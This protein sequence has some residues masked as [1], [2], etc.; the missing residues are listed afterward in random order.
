[1]PAMSVPLEFFRERTGG[2]WEL[3]P[4]SGR[5]LPSSG[6]A[7]S[8]HTRGKENKRYW[9]LKRPVGRQRLEALQCVTPN[10]LLVPDKRT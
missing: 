1:M 3:R 5:K 9:S 10:S 2:L 8:D 7:C 6:Q 4:L